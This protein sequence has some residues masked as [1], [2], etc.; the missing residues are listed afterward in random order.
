MRKKEQSPGDLG[1]GFRLL[2][3]VRAGEGVRGVRPGGS[4]VLDKHRTYFTELVFDCIDA[5]F[6]DSMKY[7]FDN[8]RRD[9]D[10]I[11]TFAESF[12][13]FR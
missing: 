2:E 11:H 9:L 1:I 4:V 7:H 12:S 3:A 8:S 6:R 10:N 5:D 13:K